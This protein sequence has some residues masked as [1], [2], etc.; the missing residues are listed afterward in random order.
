MT[1]WFSFLRFSWKLNYLW[2]DFVFSLN[3]CTLRFNTEF[4][5]ICPYWRESIGT[6]GSKSC[7]CAVYCEWIVST[8]CKFTHKIKGLN[9]AHSAI[10]PWIYWSISVTMHQGLVITCMASGTL[11]LQ[12]LAG[13]QYIQ[14]RPT[15][16]Y[17]G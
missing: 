1:V 17:H 16:F 9:Q 6:P 3:F 7:T 2:R 13:L 5:I 10:Q 4:T 11:T 14:W 12:N 8:K 15:L